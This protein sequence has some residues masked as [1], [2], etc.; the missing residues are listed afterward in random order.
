MFINQDQIRI[1]RVGGEDVVL[2][3]IEGE[4]I[5]SALSR[6]SISVGNG[7]TVW[8]KESPI[9][10]DKLSSAILEAGDEVLITG[11]KVGGLM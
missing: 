9:S 4:S 2:D 8:V 5:S 11:K 3:F 1:V 6:A 7:E 10:M